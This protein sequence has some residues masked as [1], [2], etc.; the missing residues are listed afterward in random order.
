VKCEDLPELYYIAYIE[1]V[2][3]ILIRGIYCHRRAASISHKSFAKE[4]VQERREGKRVPG[5]LLLHEYANLY[6][7]VDNAALYSVHD[8][9]RFLCALRVDTSVLQYPGVRI[10][11][12]N[13]AANTAEFGYGVKGLSIV[14]LDLVFT[15]SWNYPED[16]GRTRYHRR[17][18]CAEVLVP[19]R[20]PG[21][22]ILGV[23][24]SNV[25]SKK[26]LRQSVPEARLTIDLKPE[27][28]FLR[29]H[30]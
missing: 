27:L 2:R 8:D 23:L 17:F 30:S 9:H 29:N 12:R 4:E 28:F 13:A 11:D 26:L 19:D 21:K 5:G 22:H 3:S 1:N 15:P 18:T 14:N 25:R 16:V 6:M 20:V 10:A 7:R 24:V